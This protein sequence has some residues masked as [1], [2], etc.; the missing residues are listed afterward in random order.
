MSKKLVCIIRIWTHSAKKYKETKSKDFKLP[1]E[2]TD[3]FFRHVEYKH[4]LSIS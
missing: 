3:S 4:A 1:L 2:S